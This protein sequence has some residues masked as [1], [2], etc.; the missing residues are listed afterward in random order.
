MRYADLSLVEYA[1]QNNVKHSL[2][3]K[4]QDFPAQSIFLE[5]LKVTIHGEKC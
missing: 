4:K 1:I 3:Y 2:P 5:L